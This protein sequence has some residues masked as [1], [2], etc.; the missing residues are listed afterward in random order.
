MLTDEDKKKVDVTTEPSGKQTLEFKTARVPDGFYVKI[1]LSPIIPS[2]KA[3]IESQ[4]DG[5]GTLALLPQK[6]P[7]QFW[8][9]T[10]LTL[11]ESVIERKE[12]AGINIFNVILKT[13]VDP[14]KFK[15]NDGDLAKATI[16]PIPSGVKLTLLAKTRYATLAEVQNQIDQ[17]A[18]KLEV[19]RQSPG[20]ANVYEIQTQAEV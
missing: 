8:A 6:I 2:V 4:P 7:G 19:I 14:N 12:S 15:L 17:N 11:N 10:D 16:T 3:K 20:D 1:N 13:G 9:L 5:S 18:D